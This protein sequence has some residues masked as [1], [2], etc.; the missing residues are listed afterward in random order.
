MR[1]GKF[2]AEFGKCTFCAKYPRMH[3]IKRQEEKSSQLELC[4][5]FYNISVTDTID[6]GS[7]CTNMSDGISFIQ[8]WLST[9]YF[10]DMLR[11]HN[12]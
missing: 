9:K 5:W 10:Q 3:K 1:S 12:M 7:D 8:Q 11:L 2:F 4:I 6:L